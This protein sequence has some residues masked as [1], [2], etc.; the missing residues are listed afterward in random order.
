LAA[1][2]RLYLMQ[3]LALRAVALQNAEPAFRTLE[4]AMAMA[5]PEGF[6][7]L[8]VD[9]GEPMRR[10]LERYVNRRTSNR[11]RPYASRLLRAF[12]GLPATT[13]PAIQ[14]LPEPL[15]ESEIEILGLMSEGLSNRSE[16][17]TSE[18]QSRENLV[19]R[20][21]LENQT[22]LRSERRPATPL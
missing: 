10:L 18:L 3:A 1:G 11:L 4:E 14:N 20:L 6:V 19:Y 2:R 15:S 22:P 7:R 9:E 8:F 17:H 21:Q 16:E 13:E 5:E 12:A